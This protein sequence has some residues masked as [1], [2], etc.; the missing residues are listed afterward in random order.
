MGSRTMTTRIPLTTALTLALALGGCVAELG[1]DEAEAGLSQDELTCSGSCCGSRY[2]CRVPDRDLRRGCSG[3]R[4]RNP[5]TGDCMWPLASDADR[6]VYDGLGNRVG[7]VRSDAV[8]LNQGIRKQR[9]GRWLVYAFNTTVRMTTGELR[10]FSGWI[11][12]SDL[13]HTS[14][15]HGYTLALGDP[16]NGHYETRWQITGDGREDYEGY[17]LHA[18][19]GTRYP[20]T[21]YLLRP[22]GLV[23]LTFTVPGFNL[24]GHATDSFPPGAIFRRAR[25]V[26]QIEIPLYGPN[27]YRSSRYSL[28]FVY[29]YVHDGEGRRYGWIAKEALTALPLDPAPAPAPA[30][31]SSGPTCSARCCDG[32]V[33]TGLSADS[34]AACVSA[35]SP[36]CADHEYVL[37]ARFDGAV[38]YERDRFCWA[39]CANRSA[40]HRLDGVS[41]GCTDA[42]QAFCRVGDR[43]TFEDAMWDP[44]QPR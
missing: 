9:D 29:G 22:F 12:Q 23:H 38:S 27:G 42:A 8:R 34:A 18:I 11:R 43:G 20:A 14:H 37:R 15:L 25:G 39:K 3:A 35:S 31:P 5:A 44:C 13:V 26:D 17:F 19:D 16:G 2:N 40:Y 30:P 32:T 7:E 1:D 21:D 28:R 41:A 36:V 4:I 24:G 10:P 6:S 33:V